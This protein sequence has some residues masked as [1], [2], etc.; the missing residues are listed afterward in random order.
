[1]KNNII[2]FILAFGF[3]SLVMASEDLCQDKLTKHIELID[4]SDSYIQTIIPHSKTI[5]SF[6]IMGLQKYL[7]ARFASLKNLQK[8]YE[9][10]NNGCST[11][12]ITKAIAIY[13][14]TN[15]GKNVFTNKE[16]RRVVKGFKKFEGFE[17]TDFISAYEK[18]TSNEY[19]EAARI[20]MEEA[21]LNLPVKI[22]FKTSELDY[23]PNLYAFSDSAINGA[24]SVVAGAARAWGFISDHL[25]WRKGRIHRNPEM[26]ALVESKLKPLDL[27]FEKRT[28]VLANYTIPGH[29]G[30]VGIWLGSKE[31][32]IELGIWDQEYFK[33]F[34]THVEAG[35][36]IFELRKPGVN[37]QGLDTFLNLDEF[38]I[39]RVTNLENV[40]T[41]YAN[42]FSQVDK[43]YDF[44]F[45][46]RTADKITCSE[47][48][49]FSYGDISWNETKTLFQMSLRPDDL[50][51]KTLEAGSGHELILYL[52]G[53]KKK[54][55]VSV[56]GFEDWK[57]LFKKKK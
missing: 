47:L 8:F 26:R 31:E 3:N 39:T 42:L 1:M 20:E 45:D 54:Q 35:R 56:L 30:H 7:A 6:E 5:T 15:I 22:E 16:L 36:K 17:L 9:D 10:K 46:S 2:L 41:I 21:K 43:K 4:E 44:K 29:F 40:Q 48:I 23:D 28:F 34:Q 13:D 12:V 57:K 14:F 38:A 52:K 19:V 49:T 18:Y 27:V 37:F 53:N 25:K 32:L 24:T 55:P 33:P 51:V 50:A 11:E